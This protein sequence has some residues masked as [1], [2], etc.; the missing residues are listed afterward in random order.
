M[1]NNK[2]ILVTGGTGSFGKSFVSMIFKKYNPKKLVIFS[3]DELKQFEMSNFYSNK[4][5]IRFFIGDIRDQKRLDYAL[6]G[7]DICVHAAAMKQVVASEY[8]P[9][10]AV[11]TNIIGAEN[12]IHSCINNN[13]DKVIALSTDK[14]SSPIN[15]Y[16]VTKL[17]SD[18][19]FIAANNITGKKKTKFSVVRYGNVAGSR[20]SVIPFYTSLIKSGKK[21]LP[22]THE[23]MTRFFITLDEGINFVSKCL[24][25]MKGGEIFIPKISSL[26]IADLIRL[27]GNQIKYKVIGIRPGEKI[28]ETLFSKDESSNV[29]EF[30]D[31]FVIKPS[32]TF[33]KI[34]NYNVYLNNKGKK[35]HQD[36]EYTSKD[37]SFKMSNV[38]LKKILENYEK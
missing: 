10:E 4:K 25:I 11:K 34:I 23:D 14:A 27:F 19:I 36:F 13:V 33:N 37:V 30:P 32:I 3:R 7:I 1:F 29:L 12:V 28:H 38:K 5:N 20:G 16:G 17:A 6:R 18:K 15:L 8:N 35:V 21:T 2:S 24:K 22:L 31:F 9:L 26:K